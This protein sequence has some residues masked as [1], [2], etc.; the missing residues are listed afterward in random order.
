MEKIY[1][2]GQPPIYS[3]HRREPNF[4]VNLEPH[5]YRDVKT[6]DVAFVTKNR[7]GRSVRVIAADP[8]FVDHVR[9]VKRFFEAIVEAASKLAQS[10]LPFGFSILDMCEEYVDEGLLSP[11]LAVIGAFML[12]YRRGARQS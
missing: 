11:K 12:V 8:T 10:R 3:D 4:Y 7:L 9:L 2:Y 1:R 5:V 6:F